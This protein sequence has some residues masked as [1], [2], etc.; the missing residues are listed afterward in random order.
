LSLLAHAHMPL[1]YWDE[2]FLAAT[3]IINRLPTKVIGLST[4]LERLFK[5]KP[6]YTCMH[7]FRCACW[8]NLH[9]FNDHKLQFYSKQCVF[10]RYSNMHMGF[11]CLNVTGGRIYISRDVVF[12]EIVYPFSKLNPNAGARLRSTILLL[13]PTNPAT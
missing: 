8:P 12:D 5:E 7:I 9:P 2:D 13:P 6:H 11:K 3:Y 1:K 10:L 4:P